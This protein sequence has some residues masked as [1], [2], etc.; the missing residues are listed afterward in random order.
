MV[1]N[2]PLKI[3]ILLCIIHSFANADTEAKNET[4]G[5]PAV[6]SFIVFGRPA[7]PNEFPWMASLLVDKRFS[8]SSFIISPNYIATA[9]H[10]VVSGRKARDPSVFSAV[11][12][13]I[14]RDG[15]DKIVRFSEVIS[16]PRYGV[17]N[18]HDI[19]LLKLT[20]TL[21]ISDSVKPVCLSSPDRSYERQWARAM[22]WGRVHTGLPSSFI[23]LTT[24]MLVSTNTYCQTAFQVFRILVNDNHI[25]AGGHLSGV[26]FGDSGSPLIATVN[27]T[28]VAIGVTSFG[29]FLGCSV[30]AVPEV[31][32][33]IPRHIEWIRENTGGNSSDICVI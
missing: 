26:C 15:P 12:G 20:E 28:S 30:L 19:A 22:G 33:S 31:F 1:D 23:L 9:A 10:C 13:N 17:Q 25:C 11:V 2:F 7:F 32:T 3:F 5:P 4:V 27:S 6:D 8:C 24:P 18:S 21:T 14:L 16:H 29:T